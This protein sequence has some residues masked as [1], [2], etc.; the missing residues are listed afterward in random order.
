M[1]CVI[2]LLLVSLTHQLHLIGH[3]PPLYVLNAVWTTT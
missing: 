3:R 1:W 2:L